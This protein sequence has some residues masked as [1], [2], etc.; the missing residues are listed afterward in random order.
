MY[1][2]ICRVYCDPLGVIP[3]EKYGG[4]KRGMGRGLYGTLGWSGDFPKICKEPLGCIRPLRGLVQDPY[5]V[6]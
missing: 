6:L 3:L 5:R 2:K 4:D 1:C